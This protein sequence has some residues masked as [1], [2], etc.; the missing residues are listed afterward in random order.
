[1]KTKKFI[2]PNCGHK[3][4]FY[5]TIT[6]LSFT[7]WKCPNCGSKIKWD[8]SI[9]I[10]TSVALVLGFMIILKRIDP[11][12]W[13]GCLFFV[14]YFAFALIIFYKTVKLVRYEEKN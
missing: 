6:E 10:P 12:I 2:C 14:I 11:S 1:M 13:V 4:K 5:H 8:N 3:Q 7:K 9:G